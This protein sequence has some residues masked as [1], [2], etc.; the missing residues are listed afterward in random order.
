MQAREKPQI[1]HAGDVLRDPIGEPRIVRGRG[2]ERS[3]QFDDL[4]K[5]R[6]KALA[7]QHQQQAH[8]IAQLPARDQPRLIIVA[9]ACCD[10]IDLAHVGIALGFVDYEGERKHS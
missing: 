9:V 2:Q 7:Q 1:L 5:R 6:Y 4:F 3:H 8:Q 10:L